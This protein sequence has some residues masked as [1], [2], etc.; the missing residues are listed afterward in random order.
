VA[1][2]FIAQLDQKI[3]DAV[4]GNVGSMA[5]FRVGFED[6]EFFEKQFAPEFSASDISNIDNFNCYAKIL[7]NGVPVNPFNIK[8]LPAPDG[9]PEIVDQLKALSFQKFGRPRADI[10]LEISNR[11][12]KVVPEEKK[13]ERENP[14]SSLKN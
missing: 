3:R 5:V 4:F 6:A 2:Q 9:N 14:F 12:K 11:Y 13:T 7:A 1:H 10:E 8:A